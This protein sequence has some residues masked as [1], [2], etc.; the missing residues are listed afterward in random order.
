MLDEGS[1]GQQFSTPDNDN[2]DDDNRNCAEDFSAG[3]WF[4]NCLNASPN[5]PYNDVYGG[6]LDITEF[7]WRLQDVWINPVFTLIKIAPAK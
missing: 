4:K 3:W 1:L 7:T 5:G 6:A 2:D